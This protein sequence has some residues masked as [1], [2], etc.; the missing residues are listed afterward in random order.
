MIRHFSLIP[1]PLEMTIHRSVWH[2]NSREIAIDP[3]LDRIG[4]FPID[5]DNYPPASLPLV[6]TEDKRQQDR[7]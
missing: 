1:P 2:N 3:A 4:K 6:D 7:R 5:W